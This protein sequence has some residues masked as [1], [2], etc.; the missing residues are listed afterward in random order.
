[1]RCVRV[2]IASVQNKD[3]STSRPA[4][5]RSDYTRRCITD[6][7]GDRSDIHDDPRR[8][9][10]KARRLTVRTPTALFGTSAGVICRR[11][12]ARTLPG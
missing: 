8:R 1:M 12:P 9:L 7:R 11:R 3:A 10:S 4:L 2:E 5:H 6:P